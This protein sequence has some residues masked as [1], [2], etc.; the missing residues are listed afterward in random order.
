VSNWPTIPGETPIDIS[1]LKVAGVGTRAEL[2]ELEA[3]NIRKVVLKYL[4]RR[5]T[6]RIAPFSLPWLK[7][8]HKQ[9][10]GDVW[11]WAG[12]LRREDLNIGIHW[13]LIDQSL[14]ALVDDLAFWDQTTMDVLEAAVRLHHRAVHIHPFPNGNGRWARMLANIW[15]RLHDCS[16][17]EWPESDIGTTSPIRGEYLA[18]LQAADGGDYEPLIAIHRRF[19]TMLVRP[20]TSQRNPAQQ[21]DASDP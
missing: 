9:M 10:F 19:T 12:R 1:H 6:R 13:H 14:Q 20:A 21:R 3:E 16:V 18:A 8:L 15:L 2:N 5:P 11:K 7:R 4:G 17:T